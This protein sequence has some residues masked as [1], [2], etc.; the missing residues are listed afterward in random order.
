MYNMDNQ[1]STLNIMPTQLVDESVCEN[2]KQCAGTYLALL[3]SFV[4]SLCAFPVLSSLVKKGSSF[5]NM[6]TRRAACKIY[7]AEMWSILHSTL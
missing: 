5:D 7:I 3:L 6:P 1:N 4:I 2:T